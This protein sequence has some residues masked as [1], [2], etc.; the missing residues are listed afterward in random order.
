MQFTSREYQPDIK[1]KALN[2][3]KVEGLKLKVVPLYRNKNTNIYTQAP[4]YV[5]GKM[6]KQKY[7]SD[8]SFL[9]KDLLH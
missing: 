3:M 7:L 4:G 1:L 8:K 6:T 9:G 2:A 5:S